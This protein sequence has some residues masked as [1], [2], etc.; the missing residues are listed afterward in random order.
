M[1]TLHDPKSHGLRIEV[2]KEG[3]E[4]AVRAK[5]AACVIADAIKQQYP[6]LSRVKVDIATIRASDRKRGEKYVYLTPMPVG[7]FVLAFDQGWGQETFP[8]NFRSRPP[9]RIV[10]IVRNPAAFKMTAERR[11]T[12]LAELESKEQSGQPLTGEE[13][14]S[15][16]R[17]R[18]PKPTPDRP[19]SY[20][21]AKAE[22]V[23]DEVIVHGRPTTK[24]KAKYHKL[25]ANLLEERDRHFGAKL[26][27]PSEAF[28]EALKVAI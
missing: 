28:N 25:H 3:Y 26:A 19:T 12:R 7:E 16:T 13:K 18:N 22:L 5:S 14:R 20:G 6:Q 2:T 4:A 10:P 8:K 11:A 24:A 27:R 1:K 15:L 23:G 17:L 21:P 9:V